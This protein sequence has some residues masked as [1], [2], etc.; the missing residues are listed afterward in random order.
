M[1]YI[2]NKYFNIVNHH[3]QAIKDKTLNLSKKQRFGGKYVKLIKESKII[4]IYNI[5]IKEFL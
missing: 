5:T 3:R 1:Y 2:T 4:L